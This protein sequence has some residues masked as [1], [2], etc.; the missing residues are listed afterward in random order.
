MVGHV[1]LIPLVWP[2]WQ[3][4]LHDWTVGF[5]FIAGFF[6]GFSL[7]KKKQILL[8]S[9]VLPTILFI[10]TWNR[11]GI[12]YLVPIFSALAVLAAIFL[13]DISQQIHKKSFRV[14]I[15]TLLF[16]IPFIKI[17]YYDIRLI[18][19]D[20]RA[21]G[22]D[23]IESNIPDDSVIGYENY[24]Y[25]PNLFDPVR[26]F[27]N[28]T[29]SQLI[30]LELKEE[31]LIE[32]RKRVSYK[33]INFRKHFKQRNISNIQDQNG[34][35]NNP[36]FRQI[37]EH[38]LPTLSELQNS[39][40]EYLMISSDNYGRY[41][42]K[43]SLKKESP[44]WF[45][46]QNS[47]IFYQNILTSEDLVLLKEILPSFWNLGPTIRIYKFKSKLNDRKNSGRE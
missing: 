25:G 17:L 28:S 26:F 14:A 10:G 39:G 13:N 46:Y 16:L 24:V 20:T 45:G 31:L 42:K 6:Y 12:N 7:R 22:E 36:Y 3:L 35:I 27:K 9:F 4:V 8:L 44:L 18:H 19:R 41:L 34:I 33:L 32:R 38:T 37:L 11:T 40:V 2:F 5:L 30:P 43:I 29:E 21:L 1:S 23:W 47:R 15:I